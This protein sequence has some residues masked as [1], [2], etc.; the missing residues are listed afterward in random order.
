MPGAAST[1]RRVNAHF[2]IVDN[3]HASAMATSPCTPKSSNPENPDQNR[4]I[5]HRIDSI[6]RVVHSALFEQH[7]RRPEPTLC[8]TVRG[9]ILFP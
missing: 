6:E 9:N 7:A 5:I 1:E 3:R 2:H 4:R 8:L